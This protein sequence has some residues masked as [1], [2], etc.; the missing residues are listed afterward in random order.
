M[1]LVRSIHS[2]LVDLRVGVHVIHTRVKGALLPSSYL[3]YDLG[4][5][6]I[7]PPFPAPSCTT[8]ILLKVGCICLVQWNKVTLDR[9]ERP[10]KQMFG[11]R[12]RA[13]H[14]GKAAIFGVYSDAEWAD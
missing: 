2:R 11:V 6:S 12:A 14:H 1:G 8:G 4:K 10:P 9:E 3:Y 5:P 7:T 13:A